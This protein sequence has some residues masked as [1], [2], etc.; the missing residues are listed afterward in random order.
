M[1]IKLRFQNTEIVFLID[2]VHQQIFLNK[3][4]NPF[5]NVWN[6]SVSFN[7]FLKNQNNGYRLILSSTA[8]VNDGLERL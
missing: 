7:K 3:T 5:V 4:K 6:L 8:Y 1:Q 2:Q